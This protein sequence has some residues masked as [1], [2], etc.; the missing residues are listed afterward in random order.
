[1]AGL[2]K[3]MIRVNKGKAQGEM[4]LLGKIS[5]LISQRRQQEKEFQEFKR[6]AGIREENHELIKNTYLPIP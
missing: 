5:K 2:R 6:I 3:F 4:R 1:M